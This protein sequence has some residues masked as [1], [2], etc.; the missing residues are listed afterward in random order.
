[1]PERTGHLHE[2]SAEI[3]ELKGMLKAIEKYVHESRHDGNNLSLKLDAMRV[4]ISKDIASVEARM[5]VRFE[6]FEKRLRIVEAADLRAETQRRTATSILQSPII[7][8]IVGSV[9]TWAAL[10]FA[11]WKAK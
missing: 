4:G 8:G 10:F 11:W 6:A 1:M 3:G 9:L 2:I 7:G 5:E